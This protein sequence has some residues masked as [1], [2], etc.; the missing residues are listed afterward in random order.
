MVEDG[1]IKL[2]AASKS[3]CMYFWLRLHAFSFAI[4]PLMPS[5]NLLTPS[6]MGEFFVIQ[7]KMRRTYTEVKVQRRQIRL[8][9][10][11]F[12]KEILRGYTV[13]EFMHCLRERK[14]TTW[15]IY[16]IVP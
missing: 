9:M 13:Q 10:Q 8:V 15:S 2:I 14:F 5:S 3:N 12:P 6:F 16:V 1:I 4:K 11:R 7:G